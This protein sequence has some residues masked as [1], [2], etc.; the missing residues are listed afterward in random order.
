MTDAASGLREDAGTLPS[1][2]VVVATRD[3][4]ELLRGCLEALVRSVASPDEVT[5]V[6]SCSKGAETGEL[7]RG[8]GVRVLRAGRPGASMA[9]NLGWRSVSSEVVAFVD[10]DVRVAPGW[11]PALRRSFREHPDAGFLTGR[12][13][14]KTEERGVGRPV[15]IFDEESAFEIHTGT[16]ADLGHGA[17]LAVRRTALEAVGGYDELLGPGARWHAAEDLDLLD[18]LL[19]GGVTGRYEPAAEAFHEQWRRKGDLLKLEWRYGVGQGARL[20]RLRHSDVSRFRSISRIAWWD[21]GMRSV[22]DCLKAGYEFG[23][24][25]ALVR[26]AGTAVGRSTAAATARRPSTAAR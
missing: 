15:A 5:V 3:R 11:A 20:A 17:N 6:D 10:D 18:R 7:A 2:G 12:L 9:R 25:S 16:V 22:G 13:R 23:A 24:V 8:F 26:M 21:M 14:L 4:P 1:F 19:A